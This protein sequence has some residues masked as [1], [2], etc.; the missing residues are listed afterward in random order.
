MGSHRK[1]N[2]TPREE[3]L[4]QELVSLLPRFRRFARSLARDPDSADDIVQAACQ[5][6]LERLD[7]VREGTRLDSWIYRIIYTRWIDKLR[8]GKTRTA[9]LQIM[10]N[11]DDSTTA[12]GRYGTDLTAALD[13]KK[14]LASLPAEH[15]AAI[16]LVSVEGYSYKEAASVLDVPVGTVASRVARGRTMLGNFL[17][18]GRSQDLQ[19]SKRL[20]GEGAK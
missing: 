8:R 3:A 18:H 14:A 15:H 12:D 13:M 5:R 20:T 1:K 6:A 10:T 2:I 9:N 17:V 16:T 7:Q 4:R 11:E 19:P